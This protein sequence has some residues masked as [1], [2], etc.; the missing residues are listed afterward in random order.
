MY[1]Y[2]H[3]CVN[4]YKHNWHISTN[5]QYNFIQQSTGKLLHAMKT[6]SD[7]FMI[8]YKKIIRNNENNIG[9]NNVITA[10]YK[11]AIII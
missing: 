5:T 8:R 11:Y 2:R 4:M 7:Q 10:S 6:H 9:K 3:T 1:I